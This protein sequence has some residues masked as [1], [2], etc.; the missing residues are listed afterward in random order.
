MPSPRCVT[1]NGA[2]VSCTLNKDRFK[3]APGWKSH[4]GDRWEREVKTLQAELQEFSEMMACRLSLERTEYFAL[5]KKVQTLSRDVNSTKL[6]CLAPL[7]KD[8][9][10]MLWNT[11]HSELCGLC[12]V[13]YTSG[14]Q[15]N[16]TM[17]N[18]DGDLADPLSSTMQN[19]IT[20]DLGQQVD[21]QVHV[22]TSRKHCTSKDAEASKKSP[23][24][25]PTQST[26]MSRMHGHEVRDTQQEI[27]DL[28]ADM[29]KLEGQVSNLAIMQ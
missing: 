5:S 28:L 14:Q 20:E 13:W 24:S 10:N 22:L 6:E 26:R 8:S 15:H 2:E 3:Q 18:M 16:C 4:K 29:S 27:K 19:A 21:D 1:R 11:H 17:M 7:R 25:S 9:M 23:I 12:G